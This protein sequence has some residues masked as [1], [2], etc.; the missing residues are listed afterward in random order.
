MAISNPATVGE[1]ANLLRV[2][3][4]QFSLQ[5]FVET[6]G[7]A[8]GDMIVA[9]IAAPKW[10]AEVTLGAMTADMARR[11]RATMRRIGM[12]GH[13]LLYNYESPYPR[14]DP[15]GSIIGSATVQID[16]F[17]GRSIRL[18]GLPSGYQ[19]V[20]GDMLSVVYAGGRRAL[21]EVNDEVTAGGAGF[22]SLFEV[23]PPPKVGIADGDAVDLVRPCARMMFAEY[24]A[25][26]TDEAFIAGGISFKAIET[27]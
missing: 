5:E 9:Q 3:S 22:T 2:Q 21:Y 16:G 25:S 26:A 10:S 19:L 7:S 17:S 24:D 18:R 12:G 15:D 23:T 14:N 13:F 20:W 27:R 1:F 8:R 6:S 11:T 4:S